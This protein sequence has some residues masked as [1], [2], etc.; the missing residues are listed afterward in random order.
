MRKKQTAAGIIC[1]ISFL[2]N[3]ILPSL[4]KDIKVNYSQEED[5]VP[6]E[7]R[8]VSQIGGNEFYYEDYWGEY[9]P[10]S[11]GECGTACISMALSYLGID[12]TP[13]ELGD[14]WILKG[15]TEGV[16]FS[17]V[18]GDVPEATGGH[19]YDFFTAYERYENEEGFSPVIIYFTKELNPYQSGNRHF[20]LVTDFL[21]DGK[22]SAVDPASSERLTVK[23]VKD[24]DGELSVS[25]K[26]K[27]G[28]ELSGKMTQYQLSSAQYYIETDGKESDAP[29]DN[30]SVKTEEKPL[31]DLK[32]EAEKRT[33]N[34]EEKTI[35]SRE[36]KNSEK[37][38]SPKAE[39]TISV[40]SE[41]FTDRIYDK[42]PY[43]AA[44][45]KITAAIMIALAE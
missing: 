21:G 23:I 10:Y 33:E 45:K 2:V 39:P 6:G 17:T 16:P 7:V 19:S 37:D 27:S 13:K 26:A 5:T 11:S 4:A 28:E 3:G 8:Y 22:Y 38:L 12:K 36:R 43:S 44:A 40:A 24:E 15:Y 35:A 34:E 18:F 14:Y 42:T 30:K 31:I 41:S 9:A 1:I 32:K 20:V 29:E 25:L